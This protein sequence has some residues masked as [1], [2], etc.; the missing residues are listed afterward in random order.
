MNYEKKFKD[1]RD[2]LL[3]AS[4][5]WS[6]GNFDRQIQDEIIYTPLHMNDYLR[7][8]TI[9]S[10]HHHAI[11]DVH[12][13]YPF[14]DNSKLEV[15]YNLNYT[16]EHSD[17][18]YS[19]DHVLDPSTSYIFNREEQIHA[20]YA[21]YGFQVGKQFSAQ[22]GLRG[23]MVNNDFSREMY[24][25]KREA[26]PKDYN[27]I[28]PT[29]H[30][31]YQVNQM[32]SFQISYSRRIRRPDPW[33]MMPNVDLTNQE[34]I[35]FGNPKIDP[36]YT[37]A[38]E[39]GYSLMF[40]KTTIFTSLYYRAVNNA[41]NRFE[42]PWTE[43]NALLYEFEWA[44]AVAGADATT[45]KTAQ[46]FM[47]VSKSSN[48]GMEIIV[49]RDITDWWK[50]NLSMN[51]FGSYQDGTDLGYDK[52]RSFNYNAKLNTTFTLPKSW[53][54]QVSGR[55]YA[56][57]KTIQGRSDARY[58]VDIAIKK[59]IL[60]KQGNIGINFRDIFD[61]RGGHS[62]SFTDEYISFSNRH[63]YSRSIRVSFSYNFGKTANMRK[64]MQ[65]QQQQDS[66]SGG[67]FDEE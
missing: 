13:I 7:G 25:G 28:Y 53:S 4:F 41:M 15:G 55:Y 50:A 46:T 18:E 11:A 21:T 12:Y 34:Y 20:L 61:T 36:E 45:G 62:Y 66:Y 2:E 32:N 54:I 6:W 57:R 8:D 65:Q 26:F 37:N 58:D 5:T 52:V 44:W 49:D 48:Y 3:Y 51:F 64:R 38:Y 24:S 9:E 33:T 29:V 59:S 67:S 43:D 19:F 56:P 47:N 42:F 1:K 22:L 10:D 39:L 40:N 14:S 60:N 30:L 63:P 27:S 16:K 35:R 31:S 17:Y 23:E